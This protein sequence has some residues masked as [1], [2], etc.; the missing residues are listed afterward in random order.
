MLR[1][2]ARTGSFPEMLKER[3]FQVILISKQKPVGFSL[4]PQPDR[5]VRYR[6]EAIDLSFK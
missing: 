1:I 2:G 3:T 6:G 4:A 5:S